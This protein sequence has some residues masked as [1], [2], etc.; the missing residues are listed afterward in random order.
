MTTVDEQTRKAGASD[1]AA[2]ER[3]RLEKEW[4][5]EF[6]LGFRFGFLRKAD[7]P[8]DSVGYPLGLAA[9]PLGRRNAWW[10]GWGDGRNY[11]NRLIKERAG[12]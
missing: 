10:A 4:P 2:A 1:P 8:C 9:W 11:R 7:P 5:R 6:R 12:E 3:Q